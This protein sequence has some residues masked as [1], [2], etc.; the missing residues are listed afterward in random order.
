MRKPVDVV[1]VDHVVPGFFYCFR[2]SAFLRA[3]C[4]K[5]INRIQNIHIPDALAVHIAGAAGGTGIKK[6]FQPIPERNGAV[7]YFFGIVDQP[8][9]G[10]GV[11]SIILINRTDLCKIP[12]VHFVRKDPLALAAVVAGIH[13]I[14]KIVQFIHNLYLKSKAFPD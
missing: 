11:K 10:A 3:V 4:A 1:R 9:S 2:Q 5:R 12:A 6:I 14:S 7:Q 8:L 13:G